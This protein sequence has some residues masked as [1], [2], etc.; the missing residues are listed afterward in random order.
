MAEW[1]K[2]PVLK[3]GVR[4]CRIQSS[5]LCLSAME[6]SLFR[7]VFLHLKLDNYKSSFVLKLVMFKLSSE[8]LSIIDLL[9][10]EKGISKNVVID[11]IEDAFAKLAGGYYGSDDG[12]VVAKMNLSNGDMAFYQLYTP[13]PGFDIHS[14]TLI[15]QTHPL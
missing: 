2:A 10:E 6:N 8:I 7:P 3:T 5:N 14:G 11:A 13:I 1:L 9:S 12:E 15:I 4:F